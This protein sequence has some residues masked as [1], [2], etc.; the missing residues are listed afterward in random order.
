VSYIQEI[1]VIEETDDYQQRAFLGGVRKGLSDARW[2]GELIPVRRTSGRPGFLHG[3]GLLVGVERGLKLAVEASSVAV[4]LLHRLRVREGGRPVL[5][6]AWRGSRGRAPAR[7]TLCSP[8]MRARSRAQG[9]HP[10]GTV[11]GERWGRPGTGPTSPHS[12]TLPSEGRAGLLAHEE[13]R[14]P[15]SFWT[16]R[17]GARLVKQSSG[18][19]PASEPP[20]TSRR[21]DPHPRRRSWKWGLVLGTGP[22]PDRDQRQGPQRIALRAFVY[23]TREGGG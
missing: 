11:G 14:R 8:G 21:L 4:E 6:F 2:D 3:P 12:S 16:A 1:C 15:F 22:P 10:R 13:G 9:P 5:R 18:S 23:P 20:H 17:G 19:S 7:R